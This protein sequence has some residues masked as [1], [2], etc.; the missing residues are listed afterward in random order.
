MRFTGRDFAVLALCQSLFMSCAVASGEAFVAYEEA[1]AGSD[2]SVAMVPVPGGS[3]SM[4]SPQGE[5]GRAED[6]GP[7]REV[8]V[9]DFWMGQYEI[10]W[11]QYELFVYREE[12]VFERLADPSELERL[13]IDA[14]SGA[15]APY[16]EMSF[17]MGKNGYPAVNMTQYAALQFARWV[18][19]KTGQFYRL[20]TEAEWEYACRAGTQSPF[21]FGADAT[22][23]TQ[24]A[25]FEQNSDGKYAQP[26]TLKPNP[27]QL[28][29]MHGNVAEWTMDQYHPGYDSQVSADNP[30]HRPTELYPRVARGG[31]WVDP[32]E[33]LRCAARRASSPRWKERDPQIPKSQWWL[34][35]APFIGFRLVRPRV[36]PSAEEIG[37]Y[38][39]EAMED[40]GY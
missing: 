16:A 29:D 21:S 1:I 34:T 23:A 38:W 18:S 36:P 31:S 12:A 22:V 4:G 7:Q 19:A 37:R 25:V 30:W 39:L 11:Q 14:V 28:Y 9:A 35:N 17:G 24:Y 10:N 3:F 8:R 2:Q 20:P 26:G 13:G 5:A 6:E 15:T 27:W 32:V 40:Y 33:L